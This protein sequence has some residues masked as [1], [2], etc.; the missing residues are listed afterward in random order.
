MKQ[1]TSKR[2][3]QRVA[4][5]ATKRK[6]WDGSTP[7][8]LSA[9]KASWN[10]DGTNPTVKASQITAGTKLGR[11]HMALNRPTIYYK[12]A[13]MQNKVAIPHL[14]HPA[15]KLKEEEIK[16]IKKVIA[17]IIDINLHCYNS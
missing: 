12:D 1:E 8:K 3:N 15:D 7:D 16:S 9:T 5:G 17:E 2:C 14:N 13:V 11:I 6:R 10:T 4:A